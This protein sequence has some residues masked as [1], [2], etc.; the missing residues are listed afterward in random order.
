MTAETRTPARLQGR[1]RARC[2]LSA[3][4]LVSLALAACVTTGPVMEKPAGFALFQGE[5]W[6][7]ISPEGVSVG[8][9]TAENDPPQSL[10]FWA[11]ALKVHM[12]ASGY[13]LLSADGFQSPIGDGRLFEWVAPVNGEDWVYLTAVAV[14]ANEIALVEAAGPFRHYREHKPALMRSL[15]TLRLPERK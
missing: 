3:A 12:E 4:L 7:A 9:R 11:E 1:L 2:A 14:H 6:R 8:I 15:G 10:A 13:R 5:P